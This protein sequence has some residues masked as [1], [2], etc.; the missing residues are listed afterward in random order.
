MLHNISTKIFFCNDHYDY[1]YI[2][3]SFF[4]SQ[5]KREEYIIH[6]YT[7]HKCFNQEVNEVLCVTIHHN[8]KNKHKISNSI[9]NTVSC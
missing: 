9:G 1:I 8:L 5:G 3:S 6:G 2:L 7:Y 4:F